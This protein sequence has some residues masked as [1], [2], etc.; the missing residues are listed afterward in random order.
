[1]GINPVQMVDPDVWPV[2]RNLQHLQRINIFEVHCGCMSGSR[3][4]ANLRIQADEVLNGDRPENF[5]A[6]YGV[7]PF[8][9]VSAA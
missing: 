3:H 9:A 1:M 2:R 6:G 4:S 7:Q 5:P 8:F